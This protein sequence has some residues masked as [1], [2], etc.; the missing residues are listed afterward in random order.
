MYA[1]LRGTCQVQSPA[2]TR[3]KVVGLPSVDEKL[4]QTVSHPL[5]EISCGQLVKIHLLFSATL[6]AECERNA[7]HQRQKTCS[8]STARLYALST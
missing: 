8:G 4:K 5:R 1:S 2:S 7:L 3:G 6:I